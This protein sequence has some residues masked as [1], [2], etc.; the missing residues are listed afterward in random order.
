[1]KN[2]HDLFYMI[3]KNKYCHLQRL[4]QLYIMENAISLLIALCQVKGHPSVL[5]HAALYHCTELLN[6][7]MM[8]HAFNGLLYHVTMYH[9]IKQQEST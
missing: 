5:L 6:A 1:M 2:I 8:S 4:I 3:S 9:P 7:D